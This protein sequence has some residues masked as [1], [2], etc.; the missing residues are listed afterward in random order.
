[1]IFCWFAKTFLRHSSTLIC[2]SVAPEPEKLSRRKAK[3]DKPSA[4]K[5]SPSLACPKPSSLK[6][7]VNRKMAF[8]NTGIKSLRSWCFSRP[9]ILKTSS[10]VGWVYA[11]RFLCITTRLASPISC[12]DKISGTVKP[13]TRGTFVGEKD[14]AEE[15]PN[16][17]SVEGKTEGSPVGAEEGYEDGPSECKADGSPVGAWDGPK[18]GTKDGSAEGTKVGAEEGVREGIKDGSPEGKADG[19]LVGTWDGPWDGP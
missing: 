16:V 14:G 6:I 17:G 3:T 10:S 11:T 1:M 4:A 7:C 2:A 18:E 9:H 15:G 12:T 5:D 19:C 13:H 8:F